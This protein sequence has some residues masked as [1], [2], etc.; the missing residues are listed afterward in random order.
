MFKAEVDRAATYTWQYRETKG[1]VWMNISPTNQWASGQKTDT[2][3]ITLS[4]E[5]INYEYRL[6][7]AND[8]GSVISNVVQASIGETNYSIT[9]KVDSSGF[10]SSGY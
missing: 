10:G 4:Q 6:V 3:Q 9:N 5:R 1:D 7:A 8:N 2:L